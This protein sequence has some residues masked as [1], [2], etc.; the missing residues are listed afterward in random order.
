M[1]SDFGGGV[2][3]TG[4]T[5]NNKIVFNLISACTTEQGISIDELKQKNRNM[6]DQQLRWKFFFFLSQRRFGGFCGTFFL[7]VSVIDVKLFLNVCDDIIKEKNTSDSNLKVMN[8]TL[9]NYKEEVLWGNKSWNFWDL[10][11]P[12]VLVGIFRVKKLICEWQ[13]SNCFAMIICD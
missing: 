13:H 7:N 10:L 6:N 2:N 3:D 5:G 9:Q 4:L 12:T 1:G 8:N 11:L